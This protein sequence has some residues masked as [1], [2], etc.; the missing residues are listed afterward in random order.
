MWKNVVLEDKVLMWI[1]EVYVHFYFPKALGTPS[2]SW[3]Y[4]QLKSL[5]KD[6]TLNVHVSYLCIISYAII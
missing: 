1:K 2:G 3:H 6:E 5:W 4:L